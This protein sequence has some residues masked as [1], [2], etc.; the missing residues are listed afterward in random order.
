MD[1]KLQKT[2]KA[3]ALSSVGLALEHATP[4]AP[5]LIRKTCNVC[6]SDP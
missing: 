5:V 4:L 2:H 3:A 1:P 6:L